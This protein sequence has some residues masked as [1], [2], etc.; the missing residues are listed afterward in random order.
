M[1]DE[2][3]ESHVCHLAGGDSG[4]L[5]IPLLPSNTSADC[6]AEHLGVNGSSSSSSC[7]QW[8]MVVPSWAFSVQ[9]VKDESAAAHESNGFLHK[10]HFSPSML[11]M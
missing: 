7:E 10:A 11:D 4:S 3:F 9:L 8:H 6:L 1:C 5:I 2:A